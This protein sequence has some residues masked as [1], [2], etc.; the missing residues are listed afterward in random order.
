MRGSTEFCELLFCPT[1]WRFIAIAQHLVVS[2]EASSL[3]PASKVESYVEN[4]KPTTFLFSD[5]LKLISF[6]L[7]LASSRLVYKLTCSY[8]YH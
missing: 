6:R 7:A 1:H 3:L 8:R 2:R 5:L 4:H